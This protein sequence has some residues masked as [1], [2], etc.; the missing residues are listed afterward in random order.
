[1]AS[2]GT[3]RTQMH[4]GMKQDRRPP[5]CTTCWEEVPVVGA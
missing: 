4:W 2:A 5:Q 1:M 3:V